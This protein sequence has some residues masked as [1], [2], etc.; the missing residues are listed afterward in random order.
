MGVSD[1]HVYRI[2]RRKDGFISKGGQPPRFSKK[3]KSWSGVGFLKNHLHYNI[4]RGTPEDMLI[5][6][7]MLYPNCTVEEVHVI[8]GAPSTISTPSV[9]DWCRANNW[10]A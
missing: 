9:S 8:N 6:T 1:L 3:G 4:R 7:D 2:V 5:A 10:P